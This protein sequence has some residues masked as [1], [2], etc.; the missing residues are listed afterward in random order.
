MKIKVL[1][2]A[3]MLFAVGCAE[4]RED[5][6]LRLQQEKE[7]LSSELADID[8]EIKEAA[9]E[10]LGPSYGKWK[11]DELKKLESAE[12]KSRGPDVEYQSLLQPFDALSM[13]LF[14]EPVSEDGL[15]NALQKVSLEAESIFMS[16]PGVDTRGLQLG[17]K[18]FIP[19]AV[20]V[21]R[22]QLDEI[23]SKES[24]I[25]LKRS[26][27]INALEEKKLEVEKTLQA[28]ERT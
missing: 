7:T 10:A 13:K 17:F 21:V 11:L 8:R 1:V 26:N 14:L 23:N 20:A 2:V 28:M 18:L 25:R 27:E 16:I 3:M 19:K 9:I 12:V 5:K 24:E 15:A 4:S 22:K 6:Y